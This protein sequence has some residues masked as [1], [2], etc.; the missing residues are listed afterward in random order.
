M[1]DSGIYE[2]VNRVNGKRYIGSAVDIKRR[3]HRHLYLLRRGEHHSSH[4]QRAFAKYGEANFLFTVIERCERSDLIE[5]EQAALD[6]LSPEYNV[7]RFAGSRLGSKASDETRSKMSETRT[8]K[9]MAPRSEDNRRMIG[10][11]QRGRK[12]GP[13][14]PRTAE[15]SAKISA[16]L[17]GKKRGSYGPRG[18]LSEEARAKISAAKTGTKYKARRKAAT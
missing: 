12:R 9:K 14:K 11:M 2:I 5:R 6:R 3:W 1:A 18:P 17:T 15:H 4:L 13:Y 16:A 8:G 10:D 7:L